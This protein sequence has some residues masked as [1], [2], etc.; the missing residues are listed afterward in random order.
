MLNELNVNNYNNGF[1]FFKKRK[2][3]QYEK[4][5]YFIRII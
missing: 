5:I 3:E 1:L 4:L 2:G